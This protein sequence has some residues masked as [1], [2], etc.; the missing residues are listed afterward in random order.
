MEVKTISGHQ[1]LQALVAPIVRWSVRLG[2]GYGHFSRVVKPL[3]FSAAL[4]EMS[5]KGLKPTGAALALVSGLSKNDIDTFKAAGAALDM[6]A[7]TLSVLESINPANQVIARWV[8]LNLPKRLPL[9]GGEA[10]F[11]SLAQAIQ[12]H[13]TTP[14]MSVRLL[15]QDLERRG[16]V[17]VD[18]QTVE[19][20]SEVGRP[21][22]DNPESIVHFVGAIRDHMETCLGNLDA[23][24]NHK[25]LEQCISV[26]GLHAES[27]EVIHA[28]ARVWWLKAMRT[29]G[30]EAISLSE[31]DE[32]TGGSQRLRL[33][34]YFYTQDTST[35]SPPHPI[36]SR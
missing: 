18:G 17:K 13:V 9:K 21:S 36:H 8:T 22:L 16:L 26:D 33:G 15:L 28:M 5:E 31:R 1:A 25:Y 27:V 10:S 6:G 35:P 29:I 14:G 32:A 2:M 3:F 24:S 11:F 30:P 19:L 23:S 20:L 4:Q 12:I 34:V 7:Q